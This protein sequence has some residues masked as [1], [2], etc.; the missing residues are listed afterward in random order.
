LI[1][2]PGKKVLVCPLN[3]GLGHATRDVQIIKELLNV[4]FD[5]II[6]ADAAPLSFLHQQFTEL[7]SVIFPSFQITYP[8]NGSMALKMALSVPKILYGII[9]EH[10]HLKKIIKDNCIDIVISDNRYGLWNKKIYSIFITHQSLIKTP[11]KFK[12]LEKCLN[13][14]NHWFINKFDTCW[15]PDFDGEF[16]ISG[17]LSHGNKLPENIKYIGILSRFKSNIKSDFVLNKETDKY[18]I[19]VILSGPEPQRSILEE[20]L[21]EQI[22]ATIYK[23]LF[24]LGK[25]LESIGYENNNIKFIN[26]LQSSELEKLMLETPV[27]ISRS[28]YSTIM[29]L[30]RLNKSAILIPTP[31]Q[32]EQE[33]LA[34]LMMERKWFYAVSQN[35]FNLEMAFQK[36]FAY[37]PEQIKA[38]QNLLH[39]QIK[40]LLARD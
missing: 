6:G 21:K 13:A 37:K 14:V 39:Q 26:H 16:N 22:S 17:E 5:V 27:I 2:R 33:Y 35:D 11:F 32:T 3:W 36:Y 18:D 31:G 4:G 29:D 8:T 15:I 24:V 38:D 25:P 40:L 30:V 28:G 12:F 9:K 1:A 7:Q 34:K 20:I 19:L 10:H 23:A